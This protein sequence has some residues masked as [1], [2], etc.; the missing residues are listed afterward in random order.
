ME[1][2]GN[3]GMSR[4][5]WNYYL[6]ARRAASVLGKDW[7]AD[8]AEFNAATT[9]ARQTL[10]PPSHETCERFTRSV[11][12]LGE[13][14]DVVSV[15]S[16]YPGIP[17]VVE[18]LIPK[19]VPFYLGALDGPLTLES[20]SLDD[21]EAHALV[22]LMARADIDLHTHLLGTTITLEVLLGQLYPSV[23]LD[24]FVSL[25]CESNTWSNLLQ[26]WNPLESSLVLNQKHCHPDL[27]RCA[28]ER[29]QELIR[30]LQNRFFDRSFPNVLAEAC[31]TYL[32]H[33]QPM[34]CA[35][36]LNSLKSVGEFAE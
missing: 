10:S 33:L 28:V 14:S 9:A 22:A 3:V 25:L 21:E 11:N 30:F 13:W 17:L 32:F 26:K 19:P 6:Q 20:E 24:Q 18:L 16:Q 29:K 4:Q 23:A 35:P 1:S 8:N 27:W 2:L 31:G 7:V 34:V 15:L 36:S 12:S 5:Q